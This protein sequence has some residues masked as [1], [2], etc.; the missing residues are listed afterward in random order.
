MQFLGRDTDFGAQ[1]E[2]SAVGEA[3]GGVPIDAG[4]IDFIEEA[5]GGCGVLGDDALAVAAAVAG[6]VLQGFVQAVNDLHGHAQGEELGA[7]K[8]LSVS[9]R[10]GTQYLRPLLFERFQDGRQVG[11][12]VA[13][14]DEA[15]EGVADAD[16]TR[17]GIDDDG[18]GF[19]QVGGAVDIAVYDAGTRLDDWHAGVVADIVDEAVAATRDDEVH[20]AVGCQQ[21]VGVL[22]AGEQQGALGGQAVALQHLVDEAYD[23][24]AAVLGI[25]A[26]LE[27]AGAA[28][29]Q[30]EGEAVEADVGASLKDDA[31]HTEGHAHAHQLQAVGQ[32]AVF[33]HPTERRGQAGY[34]TQVGGDVA[35]AGLGELQAVIARVCL[36]H[37]LEV[38]GVGLEEVVH[39]ALRHVGQ[40]AQDAIALSII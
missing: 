3:R 10:G 8:P 20:L 37:A 32:G 9:P 27:D 31:N 23:G 14:D 5:L 25:A 13:V 18:D 40:L 11:E 4:G 33:Q 38:E 35:Q 21:A 16:A 26:A 19:L 17:L 34:L 2:L 39:V 12:A 15:V 24:R 29:L 6:D 22:V 30:A 1:P 28:R 36:V 7:V